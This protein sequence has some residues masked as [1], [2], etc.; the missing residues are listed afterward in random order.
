MPKQCPRCKRTEVQFNKNIAICD[1][2]AEEEAHEWFTKQRNNARLVDS[3]RVSRKLYYAMTSGI[4]E[5]ED[6][7]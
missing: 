1:E 2:C 5:P 7:H 4:I 6:F 3:N